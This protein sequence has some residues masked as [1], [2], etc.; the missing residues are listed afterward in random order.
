MEFLSSSN[1]RFVF[2]LGEIQQANQEQ[3]NFTFAQF[4]SS[5]LTMKLLLINFHLLFYPQ[6]LAENQVSKRV[7]NWTQKSA[8]AQVVKSKEE[9]NFFWRF[10]SAEC[11]VKAPEQSTAE[12]VKKKR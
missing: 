8:N 10:Q 3:V 2:F 7:L 1:A 6:V 5:F 11:K 9:N 4:V 12:E